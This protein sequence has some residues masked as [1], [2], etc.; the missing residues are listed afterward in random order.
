MSL[1]E[2]APGVHLDLR[3]TGSNV[4]KIFTVAPKR[5]PGAIR[6]RLDGAERLELG[7]DG[8]ARSYESRAVDFTAPIAYQE[9]DGDSATPSTSDTG[10]PRRRRPTPSSWAITTIRAR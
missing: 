2:L 6:V 3:A 4:E 1:G 10:W 5:D 9:D 7:A 8:A